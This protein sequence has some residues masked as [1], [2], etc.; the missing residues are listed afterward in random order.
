VVTD[1]A[2]VKSAILQQLIS[3][4]SDLKRYVGSH[5]MAGRERG[6]AASGRAD[7]F[8]GRTWVISPN[9]KSS[10]Q[11]VTA[12]EQL[13]MDLGSA[14]IQVPAE[15]HDRAVALVSHLPQ[16][17]ASLTAAQL[18]DAPQEDIALAGQGIRDTVRIAASDPKLWVQILAANKEPVT[19]ALKHLRRD[20][21]SVIQSVENIG[22]PGSLAKLSE[23]LERGN[24]GV[25]RLPGKHGTKATT[26]A[27]VT[28]MIDDKPGELARLFTEIGQ[29]QINVEEFTFEHSPSSQVGLVEISVMPA[30]ESELSRVLAERGW[31][32]VG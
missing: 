12:I 10:A 5:P 14:V 21:D 32:L 28:V 6:G 27:I 4:G 3:A 18:I 7:L 20:L 16:L 26:Y 8:S 19:Q 29:V 11:S 31:K 17:V 23:V 25:S 1:V 2:S 15:E 13:A 22:V 30:V 9:E 24:Q